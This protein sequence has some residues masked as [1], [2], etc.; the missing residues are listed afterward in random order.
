MLSNKN[1]DLANGILEDAKEWKNSTS[2]SHWSLMKRLGKNHEEVLAK[3]AE[4]KQEGGV[5][6]RRY[7]LNFG[8]EETV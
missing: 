6:I 5:I 2:K 3:I 1:T 8:T 4:I 7:N